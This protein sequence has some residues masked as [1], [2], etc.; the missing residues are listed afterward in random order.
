MA[1]RGAGPG[2]R[3]PG[4]SET[5][6]LQGARE[7]PPCPWC[8]TRLPPPGACLRL[9]VTFFR[10]SSSPRLESVS[11][12]GSLVTG[13][14][15]H[16]HDPR[17]PAPEGQCRQVCRGRFSNQGAVC[18]PRDPQW[19]CC[20]A[21]TGCRSPLEP[22]TAAQRPI[23]RPSPPAHPHQPCRTPGESWDLRAER[24][25]CQRHQAEQRQR[26]GS[27]GR[28]GAPRALTGPGE[29]PQPAR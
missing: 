4:V 3:S 18:W 11:S 26:G 14:G 20:G 24:G 17:C 2:V 22:E 23:R 27:A 13:P 21:P 19:P 8:R 9:P 1:A 6:A 29:E 12:K 16:P 15:T 7:G 5:R 25:E 10:V 28:T